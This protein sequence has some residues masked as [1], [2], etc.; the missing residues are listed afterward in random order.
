MS[1]LLHNGDIENCLLLLDAGYN[2]AK[3]FMLKTRDNKTEKMNPTVMDVMT[4]S[5]DCSLKQLCRSRIR[6]E[7]KGVHVEHKISKLQIP[8]LLRKYLLLEL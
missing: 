8:Q 5:K 2:A 7:M 1:N 3:E 6:A 4:K